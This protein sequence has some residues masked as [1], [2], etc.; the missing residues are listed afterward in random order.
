M[1]IFFKLFWFLLTLASTLPLFFA[2]ILH[3]FFITHFVFFCVLTDLF[4]DSVLHLLLKFEG[5]NLCSFKNQLRDKGHFLK[6][7]FFI[8]YHTLKFFFEV[9]FLML[10]RKKKFFSHTDLF[11][12]ILFLYFEYIL[13]LLFLLIRKLTVH[14]FLHR[15]DPKLFRDDVDIK[16]SRTLNSCK[17]PQV[18]LQGPLS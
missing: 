4:L 6:T 10:K 12:S 18:C 3:P 2:V 8:F 16:F 11:I 15:S 13:I 17:V 9:R 1:K 5:K 14:F 7:Y